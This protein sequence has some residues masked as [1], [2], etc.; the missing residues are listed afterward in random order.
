MKVD[1]RR[2]EDR[3]HADLMV[4]LPTLLV[5]DWK[6]LVYALMDGAGLQYHAPLYAPRNKMQLNLTFE[7]GLADT[8]VEER[9]K[10]IASEIVE[11]LEDVHRVRVATTLRSYQEAK[12]ALEEVNRSMAALQKVI[13]GSP[14]AL[15]AAGKL[16]GA[17]KVLVP[18]L[19][20]S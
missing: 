1:V 15:A 3:V 19:M 14:D 17:L 5:P 20:V 12:A 13:K 8:E 4:V 16:A 10:A 6:D 7:V 2:R 11:L 9:T 18:M